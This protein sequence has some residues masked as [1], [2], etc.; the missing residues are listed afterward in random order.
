MYVYV[1]ICDFYAFI[2]VKTTLNTMSPHRKKICGQT[3][4]CGPVAIALPL[5]CDHISQ[6]SNNCCFFTANGGHS[7]LV[8]FFASDLAKS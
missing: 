3:T 6:G 5:L 4:L 1:Y 8:L 7:A 2:S